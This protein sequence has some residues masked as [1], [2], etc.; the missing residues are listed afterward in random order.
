MKN[1]K[2]QIL[3]SLK[4]AVKIFNEC[5]ANYRIVGS[6]LV[7]SIAKRIFRR[8]GDLDVLLD[9]KSYPIV[10]HKLEESGYV[11]KKKNWGFFK[12][13][14]AEKIDCLGFTFLLVG[15]FTDTYFTYRM[16]PHVELRIRIEYLNP[17]NYS[18]EEVTFVGIPRSSVMAGIRQAFLNPK[19]KLDKQ[20]L[21]EF[22]KND[23]SQQTYDNL[24]VFIF[25]I[26]IPYL[27]DIF[28]FFYNIYGGFRVMFGKKY[29][30][31]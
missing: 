27:Y 13:I 9:N 5:K 23:T 17:T 16:F 29:E 15:D 2:P 6:M 21:L 4:L 30:T 20:I 10:L 12:W 14:E 31:W 26:K 8:V 3:R 19:R 22:T 25:G 28:S 24:Q 1:Q 7:T 18:F 11:L